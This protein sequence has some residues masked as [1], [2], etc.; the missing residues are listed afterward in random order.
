MKNVDRIDIN[1]KWPIPSWVP[2]LMLVVAISGLFIG[3]C[4][5]V[6]HDKYI[7]F[8]N[9]G[10]SEATQ[11]N[12]DVIFEAYNR[13]KVDFEGSG[14]LIRVFNNEGEEIASKITT[15]DLK[16]GEKQR[17]LKVLTKITQLIKNKADIGNVTVELYHSGLF[18]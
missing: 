18:N 12:I 6:A 2:M 17:F 14:I 15:I 16:A 1:K 10:V 8:F 5:H 9:I 4:G 3:R 13:S 7:V 11:A